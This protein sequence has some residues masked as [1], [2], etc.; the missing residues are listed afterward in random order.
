MSMSLLY[1]I[2]RRSSVSVSVYL[3]NG[4]FAMYRIPR[5]LYIYTGPLNARMWLSLIHK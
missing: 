4:Q 2:E 1:Y 5:S 3:P